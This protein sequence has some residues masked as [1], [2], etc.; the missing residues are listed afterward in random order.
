MNSLVALGAGSAW[1]YS[2]IATFAPDWLPAGSRNVYHEAAAVIVTLIL[3]GRM[4][5]ARA[6]GKTGAAIKRLLGLQPRTARLVRDGL[7]EEIA[8]E[9]IRPGDVL[10]V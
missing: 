3:L 7:V 2:V 10:M 6:K 4:L 1:G 9:Q 5:E 8:I